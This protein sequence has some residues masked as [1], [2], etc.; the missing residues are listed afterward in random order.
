MVVAPP[1]LPV[2]PAWHRFARA[3]LGV[4]EQPGALH[5]PRIL[6]YHKSCKGGEVA[7]DETAWCS[8]FANHCMLRAGIVGSG[9]RNARSWLTWGV[10]LA[11]PKVGCIVVF[12]RDNPKSAKGHV[13]FYVSA[14]QA[15]ILTL[16]GNQA[17]S[18]SVAPYARARLLSFRWPEGVPVPA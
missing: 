12:W 16:G 11:E 3:E 9:R 18:V 4:K 13:G 6:E 14:Q 2:P 8:A 15:S 10:E 7:D 1:P 17:N 5:N